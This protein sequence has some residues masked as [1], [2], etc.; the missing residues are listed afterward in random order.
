M[1][2]EFHLRLPL[3]EVKKIDSKIILILQSE[4]GLRKDVGCVTVIMMIIVWSAVA[5]T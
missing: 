4:S 1:A 5:I 2:N 3:S